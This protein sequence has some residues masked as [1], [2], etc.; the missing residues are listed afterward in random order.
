MPAAHGLDVTP[1]HTGSVWPQPSPGRYR[2][3]MSIEQVQSFVAVAEE[4]TVVRAARRLH[5]TQP[6]L[7]RRIRSL[8]SE[9]G[10]QLF[11]RQPFG[12]E[13][14]DAGERF[15]PHARHILTSLD[16]ARDA[17]RGRP[18]RPQPVQ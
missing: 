2:E 7:T 4:G 3:S 10:V 9:L 17:A 6:P 16:A 15:L 13:L 11:V 5:I 1:S 12:M 14:S 18:G 8:E